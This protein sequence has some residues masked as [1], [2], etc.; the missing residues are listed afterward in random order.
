M[1]LVLDLHS[2]GAAYVLKLHTGMGGFGGKH[3][4]DMNHKPLN[5][6][7]REDSEKHFMLLLS[8]WEF[9]E[10]PGN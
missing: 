4:W 3:D 5:K 10:S 7:K 6:E 2:A 1:G 8:V 9:F